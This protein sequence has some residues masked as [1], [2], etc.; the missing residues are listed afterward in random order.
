[1]G[2]ILFYLFIG[3]KGGEI[4]SLTG[5]QDE[6]RSPRLEGPRV[7]GRVLGEGQRGPPH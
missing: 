7:E 2:E 5:R 3:G 1:M 4:L 6:R